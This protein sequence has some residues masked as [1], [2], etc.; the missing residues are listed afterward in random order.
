MP[1]IASRTLAK[2]LFAVDPINKNNGACLSIFFST[3]GIFCL[4]GLG[5]TQILSGWQT[6]YW[7]ISCFD[8]SEIVVTCRQARTG[9][10]KNSHL[11]RMR[12]SPVEFLIKTES[13]IVSMVF[14]PG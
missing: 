8:F 14:F 9:N 4:T 6:V 2:F 3:K 1:F 10:F 12:F 5:M 13:W 11:N 7:I